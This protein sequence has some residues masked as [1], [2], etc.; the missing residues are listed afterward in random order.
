[1]AA[2]G[3]GRYLHGEAIG[4]GMA[5]AGWLGVR[6]GRLDALEAARIEQLLADYGIPIRLEEALDE[7]SIISL[8]RADKKSV[9]GVLRFVLAS[10]IGEVTVT[11]LDEALVREAVR[12]I[13]G[14]RTGSAR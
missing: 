14:Y 4:I 6:T 11:P 13:S 3:Y 2:A 5:A 12:A 8:M 9:A 1:E 7:E 10:R